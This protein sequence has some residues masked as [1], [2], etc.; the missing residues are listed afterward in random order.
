MSS[1]FWAIISLSALMISSMRA[2]RAEYSSILLIN[3]SISFFI[4]PP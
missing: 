1:F 4:F 3:I 2:M